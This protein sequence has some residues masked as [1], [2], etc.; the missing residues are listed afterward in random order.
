MH[1]IITTLLIALAISNAF[2]QQGTPTA[3]DIRAG[4][5]GEITS[6]KIPPQKV[7]RVKNETL[8]TGSDSVRIRMYYGSAKQNLPIIYNIYGGALVA[9]DLETHDNISR[10]LANRTQSLVIAVD[11][12]KPPE[13]PFPAGINDCFYV[14]Q[15]IR[16]HAANI[17]GS[18]SNVFILGDSGGGLFTAALQVKLARQNNRAVQPKALI[19]INPATELRNPGHGM[20]G[21]VTQWYLNGADSSNPLASP[22]LAKNFSS[23]PPT[24]VIV[25]GKDE[26]KPHGVKLA[27]KLRAAKVN[28]TLLDILNQDHLGGLWAAAHPQAKPAIDAAVDFINKFTKL[29]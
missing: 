27:Q 11:Y 18:R 19:L 7:I 29:Q 28:V 8:W 1:K 6:F 24:L 10:V 5:A 23:F 12:A 22:I 26:L 4:I 15:W 3:Q 20:Y 16:L 2:G 21:L 9:G 25:C 14:W 13:H 17:G